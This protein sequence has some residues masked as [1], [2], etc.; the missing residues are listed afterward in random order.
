MQRKAPNL[1]AIIN[2]LGKN[3]LPDQSWKVRETVILS[4]DYEIDKT[5]VL[6]HL[7]VPGSQRRRQNMRKQLAIPRSLIDEILY[8]CHDDVTAGHLSLNK[9]YSKIQDRFYGKGM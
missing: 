8:A 5:G 6:Y 9:M 4:A 1:S 7:F 3:Q 2:Y